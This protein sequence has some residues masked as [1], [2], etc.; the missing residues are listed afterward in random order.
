VER[1]LAAGVTFARA[2]RAKSSEFAGKTFVFTG[3]LTK[4]TREEAEAEVKRRGGKATS[5][6]SKTTSYVVAGDKAGSKLEKAHKLGVE[7]IDEDE[8]LKMIGR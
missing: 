4:L 2:P 5:S 7:V 8:F 6:V 1:L 3:A